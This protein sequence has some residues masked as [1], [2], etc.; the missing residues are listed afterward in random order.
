M[1]VMSFLVMTSGYVAAASSSHTSNKDFLIPVYRYITPASHN[2]E[3]TDTLR[4]YLRKSI[5]LLLKELISVKDDIVLISRFFMDDMDAPTQALLE[6]CYRGNV[7]S[8]KKRIILMTNIK[9]ILKAHPELI[10]DKYRIYDAYDGSSKDKHTV[11]HLYRLINFVADLDLTVFGRLRLAGKEFSDV[12]GYYAENPSLI[13]ERLDELGDLGVQL[14][15]ILRPY[16]KSTKV[17]DLTQNQPPGIT[18]SLEHD[19]DFYRIHIRPRNLEGDMPLPEM[20]YLEKIDG[21]YEYLKNK[22]SVEQITERSVQD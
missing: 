13:E 19:L 2:L 21:D 22:P 20:E 1:V 17:I 8:L 11:V 7:S 9:K 4:W 15:E 18:P 10:S 12:P 5:A 16:R 3:M 6:N 14:D